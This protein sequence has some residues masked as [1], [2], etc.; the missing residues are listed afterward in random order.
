MHY[1]FVGIF[2]YTNTYNSKLTMVYLYEDSLP[3]IEHHAPCWLLGEE[4]EDKRR[5]G[6]RIQKPMMKRNISCISMAPH[7]HFPIKEA[8]YFYLLE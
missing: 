4:S 5:R 2:A 1:A 7:C 6:P 8:S 3:N